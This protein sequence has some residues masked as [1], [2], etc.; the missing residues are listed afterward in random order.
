[1]SDRSNTK[2]KAK[3][4]SETVAFE[5]SPSTM[6]SLIFFAG[7]EVDSGTPTGSVKIEYRIVGFNGYVPLK[8]EN[9]ADVDVSL[10][11]LTAPA[12]FHENKMIDSIRFVPVGVSGGTFRAV[13]G[14]W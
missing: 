11:G 9:D 10:S 6:K 4:S 3:C 8:D 13:C 5:F 12:V 2:S 1:M 7:V 14:G